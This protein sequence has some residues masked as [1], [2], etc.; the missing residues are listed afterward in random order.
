MVNSGSIGGF[1]GDGIDLGAGGFATNEATAHISGHT[2]GVSLRGFGSVSNAGTITATVGVS[3]AAGGQVTNSAHGLI[4]GSADGIL[5]SGGNVT[6][7][8]A[9]TLS[10]ANYALQFEGGGV[11]MLI[12]DPGALFVGNV[13]GVSATSSLV[14][15]SAASTGTIR[16]WEPSSPALRASQWPAAPNGLPAVSATSARWISTAIRCS[17]SLASSARPRLDFLA[18]DATVVFG[19]PT[20]VS[21]T[22]SGFRATDTLDLANFIARNSPLPAIR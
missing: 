1:S 7:T 6:V 4:K 5:V 12:V 19:K 8:N 10:G 22:I 11:D 17:R 20:T 15:A 21:A 13:N 14:L 2:K 3:L 16:A 9:A 18:S